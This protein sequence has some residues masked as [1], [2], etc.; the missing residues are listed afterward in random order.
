MSDKSA[1]SLFFKPEGEKFAYQVAN[2]EFT[3]HGESVEGPNTG[4]VHTS[5]SVVAT[6]KVAKSGDLIATALCNI[7]GLWENSLYIKL[8]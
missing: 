3:A 7:H 6:M 5:H 8:M 4:P 2:F 1:F